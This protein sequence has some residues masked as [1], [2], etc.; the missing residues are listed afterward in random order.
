MAILPPSVYGYR[1][2]AT[3]FRELGA[4]ALLPRAMAI[5]EWL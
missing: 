5:R 4:I 1:Q 3:Q 2:R